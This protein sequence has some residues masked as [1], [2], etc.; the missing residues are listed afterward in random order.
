MGQLRESCLT[1][2]AR[3]SAETPEMHPMHP[4]SCR[5]V[6]GNLVRRSQPLPSPY[7]DEPTPTPAAASCSQFRASSEGRARNLIGHSS[8]RNHEKISRLDCNM[9]SSLH[10]AVGNF[11]SLLGIPQYADQFV[12]LGLESLSS[13]S[14]LSD[15]GLVKETQGI[16]FLPGHRARLLRGVLVLREAS[17]IG[18]REQAS[19]NREKALLTCLA[20]SNQ[21][22]AQQVSQQNLELRALQV[23][24]A[25]LA[26]QLQHFRSRTAELEVTTGTQAEQVR[27]L[28]DR[29]ETHL[30]STSSS[31]LRG[32]ASGCD[33]LSGYPTRAVDA[34]GA[35]WSRTFD[36][37]N[38]SELHS[39]HCM[40]GIHGSSKLGESKETEPKAFH[41]ETVES[42]IEAKGNLEFQSK[43][44][45]SQAKCKQTADDDSAKPEDF[46][47]AAPVQGQ[48]TIE[49]IALSCAAVMSSKMRQGDAESS[50]SILRTPGQRSP[51]SPGRFEIAEFLMD[52]WNCL[53]E[54]QEK[55]QPAKNPKPS[56]LSMVVLLMIYLDR[57]SLSSPPLD[58]T[59]HNWQRLVFTLM[60]LAAKEHLHLQLEPELYSKEEIVAFNEVI[61]GRLRYLPVSRKDA[62]AVLDLL[63]FPTLHVDLKLSF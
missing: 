19:K 24:N 58:V 30:T 32:P 4:A 16:S 43:V 46:A 37:A 26:E 38:D 59:V 18:V 31:A 49:G 39:M 44:F 36:Q 60:R 12:D 41:V 9:R 61:L 62:A 57:L 27:F 22:L 35:K 3:E 13:L 21:D 11:L 63:G 50:D 47:M 52:T 29:L 56:F 33:S 23:Q 17:L 45:P 7:M 14:R 53:W 25:Q 8:E 54:E 48:V 6:S 55:E 20:E 51:A 40:Q 42:R 34:V 15:E 1:A 5:C 2:V 10:S 28:A